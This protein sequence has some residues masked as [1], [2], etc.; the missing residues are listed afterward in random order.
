MK[1]ALIAEDFAL[2]SPAQQLRDR[3]RVGYMREGIFHSAAHEVIDDPAQADA[4]LLV[5]P[6]DKSLLPEVL[7]KAREKTPVFAYGLLGRT[8]GD[9]QKAIDLAKERNIPLCAGSVGAVLLQLPQLQIPEDHRVTDALAVAP[10]GSELI[11][12]DG[13]V[14]ILDSHGAKFEDKW[15]VRVIDEETVWQ[16]RGQR[17]SSQLLEAALSRSDKILGKTLE[18]GR[19]ENVAPQ[20]ATLAKNPRMAI[21]EAAAFR[22][23]I[24]IVEELIG[25]IVLA[26]ETKP[27]LGRAQIHST[28][29]FQAPSPQQEHFSRLAAVIDDFFR[30]TRTPWTTT[31]S[32]V[33]AV[34]G[35]Q[36]PKFGPGALPKP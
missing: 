30:T 7:A 34:I 24:L 17:W 3:F 31:R 8:R 32:Y 16:R 23:G 36:L 13:L 29:L 20:I 5:Q 28:Q 22:A 4:I 9:G 19:T 25:D 11:A 1:I 27:R 12:L 14:S 35:E 18:D 15:R 21:Y 6:K 33:T 10:P 2:G 26:L